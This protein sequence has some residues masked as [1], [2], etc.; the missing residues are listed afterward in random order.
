M[1]EPRSSFYAT[2]DQGNAH[3]FARIIITSS[4]SEPQWICEE[5][6]PFPFVIGPETTSKLYGMLPIEIMDFIG[7]ER[8]FV[9][10]KLSEGYCFFLVFFQRM[11]WFFV[12]HILVLLHFPYLY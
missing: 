8:L 12:K 2:A 4:D 10:Q 5:N 11:D 6:Q 1:G 7:Y 9:K 3:F